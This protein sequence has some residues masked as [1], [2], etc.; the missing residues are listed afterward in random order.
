MQNIVYNSNQKTMVLPKQL[1]PSRTIDNRWRNITIDNR[2]RNIRITVVQSLS[3]VSDSVTPRT[4]VRQASLFITNSQ[5]FL[6]LM[7]IQSVMPPNH[8]IL[9]P[10]LSSCLQSFPAMHTHKVWP[11]SCGSIQQRGLRTGTHSK[12]RSSTRTPMCCPKTHLCH[13]LPSTQ[14]KSITVVGF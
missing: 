10:L 1:N 6:K 3:R 9:C 4:A 14:T 11:C 12:K 13:L 5:S 7:S 2:Q 8:L